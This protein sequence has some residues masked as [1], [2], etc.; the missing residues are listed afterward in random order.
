VDLGRGPLG[1]QLTRGVPSHAPTAD[2]IEEDLDA[3][4]DKFDGQRV[5][6]VP[7][8]VDV[9]AAPPETLAGQLGQRHQSG[10]LETTTIGAQSDEDVDVGDGRLIAG[11]AVAWMTAIPQRRRD[12]R[13]LL[14]AMVQEDDV[15][16][17]RC[18][19]TS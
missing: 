2:V 15:I 6:R 14:V 13:G 10:Q 5:D 8:P 3:P 17:L 16:P 4:A 12:L 11:C 7:R 1:E 19:T 9:V 18:D